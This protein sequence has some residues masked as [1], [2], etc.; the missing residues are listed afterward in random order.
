MDAKA[1]KALTRLASDEVADNPFGENTEFHSAVQQLGGHTCQVD[2]WRLPVDGDDALVCDECGRRL[3]FD[4]LTVNIRSSIINGYE[5]RHGQYEGLTFSQALH[6]AD[7]KSSA[8]AT[9]VCCADTLIHG[10]RCS[11]GR[12]PSADN[13]LC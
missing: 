2:C 10:E 13:A 4:E 6:V 3:L 12:S 5:R 7:D 9:G 11:K 8:I 1:R